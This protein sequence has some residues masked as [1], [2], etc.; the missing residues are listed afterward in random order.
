M[1][2]IIAKFP[3]KVNT[4][5]FNISQVQINHFSPKYIIGVA[6][7]SRSQLKISSFNNNEMY[8]KIKKNWQN[9]IIFHATFSLGKG[10]IFILDQKKTTN[11]YL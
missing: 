6:A 7:S 11:C 3:K 4:K 9:M 8:K 2:K 1:I 10:K 5:F